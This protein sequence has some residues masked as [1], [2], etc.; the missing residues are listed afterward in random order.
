MRTAQHMNK[1][2]FCSKSILSVQSGNDSFRRNIQV[3]CISLH[4][5]IVFH[6]CCTNTLGPRTPVWFW[7]LLQLQCPHHRKWRLPV[8]P[9]VPPIHWDCSP[10]SQLLHP[11]SSLLAIAVPR[12]DGDV[13]DMFDRMWWQLLWLLQ[14]LDDETL[15]TAVSVHLKYCETDTGDRLERQK[16]CNLLSQFCWHLDQTGLSSGRTKGVF[17]IWMLLLKLWCHVGK[18]LFRADSQAVCGRCRQAP[19]LP[20]IQCLYAQ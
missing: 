11:L 6:F 19:A 3:Y 12:T 18:S 14:M 7:S 9:Y 10:I 2:S 20:E 16:E 8:S 1:Y 13:E 4:F 17:Q 15:C 5:F